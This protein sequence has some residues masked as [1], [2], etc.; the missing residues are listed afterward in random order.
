[1]SSVLPFCDE[2]RLAGH[3]HHDAAYVAGYDRKAAFDPTDDLVLLRELGLSGQSTL[4]DLGAGTGTF[5]MAAA[6]HCG[7]V[8]AV[9]V[10]S[11]MLAAVAQK[12]AQRRITNVRCV[13]A[14]FLSYE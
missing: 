3:E 4:I 8:I 2:I 9:D 5:A 12:T 14:G 1:M 11:A 10:S 7:S 13:Q 6:S